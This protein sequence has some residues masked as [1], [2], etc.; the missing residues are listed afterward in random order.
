[1]LR[2]S[3]TARVIHSKRKNNFHD[4]PHR[5]CLGAKQEQTQAEDDNDTGR[6]WQSGQHSQAGAVAL[7]GSFGVFHSDLVI[8]T[9]AVRAQVKRGWGCCRLCRRFQ[10]GFSRSLGARAG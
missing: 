4:S 3:F 2:V 1:M 9:H 8:F 6:G 10:N 5:F 7:L